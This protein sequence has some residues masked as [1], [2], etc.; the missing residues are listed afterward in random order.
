MACCC[1]WMNHLS[2]QSKGIL[3]LTGIRFVH[4]GIW[5]KSIV[6]RMNGQPLFGNRI[7][8]NQ[9]LELNLMLPTGFT[10]NKTKMAFVGAEVQV[11]SAKGDV[12]WKEEN[13]LM[14]K[15]ATGFSQK[16]LKLLILKFSVAEGLVQ[17]NS[18]CSIRFRIYDLKGKN[19]LRLEYP[20]T[21]A[22]PREKVYTSGSSQQLNAPA[23]T[24][25]SLSDMKAKNNGL[26]GYDDQYQPEHGLCQDRPDRDRRQFDL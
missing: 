7:P 22:Y 13:Q 18:K 3:P 14:A 12:L 15:A 8:L 25:V 2:A 26:G 20:V 17:P 9:Q 24:L 10:V 5:S 16:D 19:Q 23:G 4:E 6:V 21:I 1:L 11:V